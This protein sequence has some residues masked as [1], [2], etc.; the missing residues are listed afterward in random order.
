MVDA[1]DQ[2]VPQTQDAYSYISI[3]KY[4]VW[5][6]FLIRDELVN[7]SSFHLHLLLE[8]I[9]IYIVEVCS[10]S[11]VDIIG[12][13]LLIHNVCLF[14]LKVIVEVFFAIAFMNTGGTRIIL[15]LTNIAQLI[16]GIKV[17]IA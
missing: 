6:D 2:E 10:S 11:L 14:L 16:C 13:N 3:C 15:L 9:I 5:V 7:L 4:L 17:L 8:Q 1:V 12:D